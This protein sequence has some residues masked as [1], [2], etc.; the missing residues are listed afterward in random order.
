MILN[1]L[2]SVFIKDISR[3]HNLNGV[4][5]MSTTELVPLNI[6]VTRTIGHV[7][8]GYSADAIRQATD[9]HFPQNAPES[10]LGK[11]NPTEKY[12]NSLLVLLLTQ[13]HQSLSQE[14]QARQ[15]RAIA[16]DKIRQIFIGSGYY[17][18]GYSFDSFAQSFINIPG[19]VNVPGMAD[20]HAEYQAANIMF[21]QLNAKNRDVPSLEYMIQYPETVLKKVNPDLANAEHADAIRM[22]MKSAVRSMPDDAFLFMKNKMA[23]LRDGHAKSI[24]EAQKRYEQL[25]KPTGFMDKLVGFMSE[26]FGF[27]KKLSDRKRFA[28]QEEKYILDLSA[29][30]DHIKLIDTIFE[31][32]AAAR[33]AQKSNDD[34]PGQT[35]SQLRIA[36]GTTTEIAS[37]RPASVRA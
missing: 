9:A 25:S 7:L 20:L 21:S 10:L 6:L 14:A 15:E 2:T 5:S 22:I 32:E 29:K 35:R 33:A 34:N 30:K 4:N 16:E 31:Q 23:A 18:A 17:A 12:N 24:S 8:Q 13:C 27:F 11:I 3:T 28:A 19:M 26:G 37:H 1:Y 36:P